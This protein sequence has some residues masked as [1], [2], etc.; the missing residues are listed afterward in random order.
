VTDNSTDL[1]TTK[2]IRSEKRELQ[3]GWLSSAEYYEGKGIVELEFSPKKRVLLK[4]RQDLK[5]HTDLSFSFKIIKAARKVT[6]IE[7]IIKSQKFSIEHT[8]EDGVDIHNLFELVRVLPV[9]VLNFSRRTV[10]L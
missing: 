4:A 8:C 9:S 1:K 7:F 5:N 2:I 10:L 6:S 3:V